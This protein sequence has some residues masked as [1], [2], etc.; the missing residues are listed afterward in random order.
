MDSWWLGMRSIICC[1]IYLPKSFSL[2]A[3]GTNQK[4]STVFCPLLGP[5][6]VVVKF[7]VKFFPP[8]HTQLQEEL[9]R[10]VV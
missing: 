10:L 8:D 5:K 6:H 3:F 4:C 1:V 2:I 7:V 9:T